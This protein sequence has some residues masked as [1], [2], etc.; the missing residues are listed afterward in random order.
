M[1]TFLRKMPMKS[2]KGLKIPPKM[3]DRLGFLDTEQIAKVFQSKFSVTI[4]YPYCATPLN[5]K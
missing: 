4:V 2:C 1:P 5:F 3:S